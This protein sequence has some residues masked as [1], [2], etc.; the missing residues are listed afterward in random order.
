MRDQ[1]LGA[2]FG[3][4]PGV[5]VSLPD[6]AKLRTRA[7]EPPVSAFCA[8]VRNVLAISDFPTDMFAAGRRSKLAELAGSLQVVGTIGV[9][10]EPDLTLEQFREAK[11]WSKRFLKGE[12][13]SS[14]ALLQPGGFSV[15]DFSEMVDDS[16]STALDAIMSSELVLAWTAFET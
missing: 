5:A 8:T 2:W 10:D 6:P 13:K 11:A 3:T 9:G 4:V 12:V 15:V 14:L 16:L 1:K 7:L